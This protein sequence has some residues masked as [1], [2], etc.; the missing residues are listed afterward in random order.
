MS[1]NQRQP[2]QLGDFTF[3]DWLISI[4]PVTRFLFISS[5]LLT[6]SVYLFSLGSWAYVIEW[7]PIIYRFQF[8]R[9]IGTFLFA[10]EHGLGLLI[11]FYF[12]YQYSKQ[13][14][15]SVFYGKLDE[16]SWMLLIVCS[17]MLFLSGITPDRFF[18]MQGVFQK[19]PLYASALVLSIV[20]VWGMNNRDTT[21]SLYGMIQIPAKYLS[22]VMLGLEFA[23]NKGVV[24]VPSIQ[25]I[26]AG[27]FYYFMRHEYPLMENGSDV[28]QMPAR[29]SEITS[30]IHD[31]L[32]GL[33]GLNPVDV[34]SSQGGGQSSS[35]ATS[36]GTFTQM[37]S[38]RQGSS[39]FQSGNTAPRSR[40]GGGYK[41]GKGRTLGSS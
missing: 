16:Y 39:S 22:L 40:F 11:H 33:V 32:N 8:L 21:V 3:K 41:W 5:I 6:A 23:M 34:S 17:S 26:L 38:A 37:G 31:K 13:I 2:G 4:P 1:A 14:E 9:L 19:F 36:A 20:H 18:L 35:F 24:L 30:G 10:Y 28:L 7:S 27:H 15:M 29:W 12:L 25:G